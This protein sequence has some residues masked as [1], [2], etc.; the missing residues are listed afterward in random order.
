MTAAHRVISP[1]EKMY[2]STKRFV[3]ELLEALEI[4][5]TTDDFEGEIERIT[6]AV[7]DGIDRRLRERFGDPIN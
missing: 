7:V 6:D 5:E 3:R 2:Q 1:E 4:D